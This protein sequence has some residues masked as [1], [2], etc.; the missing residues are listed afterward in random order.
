MFGYINVMVRIS[1]LELLYMLKANSRT[2]YTKIAKRLHVSETAVRK[3]VRRLEEDGVIRNYTIEA[4]PRKIGYEVNAMIGIDT[5]PESYI[6]VIEKVKSMYEI[7]SLHSSTGDHMLIIEAWFKTNRDLTEFIKE[8]ERI[9]GV[10]KICP[11]IILD[12]IK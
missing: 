9:E 2:P 4:D 7:I 5:K 8:L 12:R 6:R 10:T 11:A 3:K 1:N